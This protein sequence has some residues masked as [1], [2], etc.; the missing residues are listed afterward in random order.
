MPDYLIILRSINGKEKAE[1]YKTGTSVNTNMKLYLFINYSCMCHVHIIYY[2]LYFK[3]YTV[4]TLYRP[5]WTVRIAEGFVTEGRPYRGSG[6][7]DKPVF[8]HRR[9]VRPTGARKKKSNILQVYYMYRLRD[10][11]PYLGRICWGLAVWAQ[12]VVRHLLG[13]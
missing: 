1:I 10:W 5:V 6:I 11:P 12:S 13:Q 7:V 2:W 8:T 4:S 9:P 3:L